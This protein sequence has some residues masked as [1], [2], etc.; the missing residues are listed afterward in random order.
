M[1]L[2]SRVPVKA[3]AILFCLAALY[4]IARGPWRAVGS[5][6]S[7]DFASVYGA[8]RCWLHNENPYDMELVDREVHAAG[9]DP[10]TLPNTDPPPSV[11]L[12]TALPLV[13]SVAWLPWKTARLTWS[14]LSIAVFGFSAL[15]IL[16]NSHITEGQKW[17]V[18]AGLLLFS[19]TSS[20]LSTGNPSVISCGLT[21][22]ALFLALRRPAS[23]AAF[24]PGLLPA[25]LLGLAHSLK[26]QI[27][28]AALA[29]LLIWGLWRT[30]ALSL[31]V[32]ALAALLSFLRAES[33]GRYRLWIDTLGFGLKSASVPGG[34]NDPS[35]A[36]YFSYHLVNTAAIASVW[37]HDSRTVS[38]LVCII[39]AALITAYLLLRHRSCVR[40]RRLRDIAFFCIVSLLPVYH[41]YYDAQLLL[42]AVGFLLTVESRHKNEE[43]AIWI[44]LLLL[45]FPLQAVFAEAHY[46]LNPASPV[47]F[48]L[49]RH[50]PAIVLILAAL[51]IPWRR[52]CESPGGGQGTSTGAKFATVSV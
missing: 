7:Y 16:R 38:V 34:I 51:L 17:L 11:Y 44:G 39:T 4:F 23:A 28:V 33:L 26:P 48:L 32:P 43:R 10:A 9:D 8:A 52:N 15:L 5:V 35:P 50:Q 30:M 37:L 19:P 3:G 27:S 13:A 46:Q 36:N 47:G 42:G 29:P 24:I 22:G 40:T 21:L 20:G 6:N 25:F 1:N 41:R 2:L 12:P 14:L 49:L 31:S 18:G 45:L